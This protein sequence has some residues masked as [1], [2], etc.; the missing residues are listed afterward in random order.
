TC[1]RRTSSAP[2][3]RPRRAT[4][5]FVIPLSPA[6]LPDDAHLIGAEY[7]INRHDGEILEPR[8]RDQHAVERVPVR[9]RQRARRQGMV[10]RDRQAREARLADMGGEVKG[11]ILRLGEL[12]DP[13]FDRDLPSGS[14]THGY[15]V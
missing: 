8:L 15:L 14:G 10:E 4:A 1:S 3:D 6:P 11:D 5:G 12:A 9:P 2:A 13:V 7:G